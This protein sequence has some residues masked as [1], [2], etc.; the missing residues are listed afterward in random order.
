MDK[1][2]ASSLTCVKNN[3]N[4]KNNKAVY[5][6]SALFASL[7]VGMDLSEQPVV[8]AAQRRRQRRLRSWLRHERMTVAMALAEASHHTGPRGQKNA[9]AGEEESEMN[10]TATVRA[11]FPPTPQPE[12]F[13]IFEEEPVGSRLDR[14]ASLSGP[15]ER[16]LRRTVQQ[17]VDT[18]P[19]VPL[20][21][22]PPR[23]KP[24]WITGSMGTTSGSALT[25]STGLSGSGCCQT[26]FSGTRCGNGTDGSTVTSGVMGAALAGC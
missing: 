25:L 17:N 3:N 13:S 16:D 21:D 9:R 6:K 14:I 4:N 23:R 15:Q 24:I 1:H 19:L 18:V 22:D 12:L 5:P 10:Y 8:G 20:L 7:V 26:T 2:I 11:Q